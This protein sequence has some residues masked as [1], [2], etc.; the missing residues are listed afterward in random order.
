[1]LGISLAVG[2]VL[3]CVTATFTDPLSSSRQLTL[4]SAPTSITLSNLEEVELLPSEVSDSARLFY[5]TC[6]TKKVFIAEKLVEIKV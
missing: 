6:N 4:A 2:R 3:E 5:K 1:M